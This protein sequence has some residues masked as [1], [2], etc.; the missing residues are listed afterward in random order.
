LNQG[1]AR[2]LKR[3]KIRKCAA[4]GTLLLVYSPQCY[5]VLGFLLTQF[6]NPMSDYDTESI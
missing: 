2:T 6:Y 1:E 3:S 4:Y 5:N